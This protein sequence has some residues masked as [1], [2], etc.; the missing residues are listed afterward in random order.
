MFNSAHSGSQECLEKVKT[1]AWYN[2]EQYIKEGAGITT[3]GQVLWYPLNVSQDG[4]IS[5]FDGISTFPDFGPNAK[6]TGTVSTF[7]PQKVTT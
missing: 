3:P 2:W 6:I 7:I 4:T 5:P 1:M